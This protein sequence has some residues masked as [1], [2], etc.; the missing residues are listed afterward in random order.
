MSE[1]KVT[2]WVRLGDYIEQCDE[3]AGNDFTVDDVIGIS[4]DKKFIPTK[5]NM[6]GVSLNS[7][8]IVNPHE[9][10]YVA[11][12]SRRGDKIALALNTS[13]KPVLI[14]SIYTSFRSKDVIKLLPEYL[15][16]LLNRAEFDRY[17][18][19][20][21]WGSARETFDWDEM[22][23]IEIPLPDI[24]VQRE[25]VATYNGLKTLAEQNE[26]LL[27]RLSAACHAYIVDCRAKYPAVPLG[28]YIEQCDERAGDNFTVDNVIGISNV[29]SLIPT[30]ADM[31]DVSL[32]PYKL[33]KPNEFCYVT[34]TSRNGGK[35]SLA[36][37]NTA[38]TY[39]VSSSYLVF[40]CKDENILL[41]EYLF[42]L[43]NRTEFDRYTRF[44]SWGSARET[45]DWSEM[46]RV[47]IPVPPIEIQKA[48]VEVFSCSERAKQIA[49]KARAR[50]K[51]LCP[52]LVQRAANS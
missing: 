5:A 40:C 44:N 24:E 16:M 42:L 35:I 48:I 47:E 30:K 6:D 19:F 45:F 15:F 2:R 46:C 39:I 43:L 26:A 23:R 11:D 9:F 17:A 25:L 13:N 32:A 20:N 31:K 7:Y 21:S 18:R 29:K 41:P 1:T 36:M 38:K 10:A 4:T 27:P 49:S 12:T 33:F 34:V 52:A 37:N 51:N 14:S 28:E 22:C 50:M 3:R 8:K